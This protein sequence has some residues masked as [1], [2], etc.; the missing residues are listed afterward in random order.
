M[1]DFSKTGLFWQYPVITEKIFFNQNKRYTNYIGVPWAT[2]IDKGVDIETLYRLIKP[3]LTNEYNYTCCQ[4]IHYKRLIPLFKSLNITHLFISHKQIGRD[5]IND[6]KLKPCPLYAV[7]IEDENRN[8]LFLKNDVKLY[9]RDILYSFSGAYMQHYITDTRQKIFK[10]SHPTGCVVKNTGIWHFESQVYS[11]SQNEAGSLVKPSRDVNNYNELLLRSMFSLCPV[12][13]GPN[14]IRFWE[15]LGAGSI[16]VVLSD[17]FELPEH[18]LWEQSIVRVNESDVEKLPEILSSYSCEQIDIMRRNCISLYNFFK[19]NFTNCKFTSLS[20][21]MPDHLISSHYKC[22][23]HFVGDHVYMIYKMKRYLNSIGHNIQSINVNVN[24]AL[25][26]GFADRLYR[27]IFTEVTYNKKRDDAINAG[28]VLGSLAEDDLEPIYLNKSS[29]CNYF[30]SYVYEN[31][32]QITSN[33]LKILPE[34]NS[35]F[36]DNNRDKKDIDILFVNRAPGN[37]RYIDNLDKFTADTNLSIKIIF[38]ENL[39]IDEQIE[40]IKRSHKVVFPMGSTQAH[41]FWCD[42]RT[43]FFEIPLAGHRYINSLLYAKQLNIELHQIL[44]KY[45]DDLNLDIIRYH[46]DHLNP[47]ISTQLTAKQI[48]NEVSWFNK[49]LKSG[50]FYQRQYNENITLTEQMFE[51]IVSI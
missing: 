25:L 44:T 26:P 8:E 31:T 49:L 41:M 14:T 50:E 12:G 43:K 42:T 21:D 7:N 15:S 30:E 11:D 34:F 13:A 47:L 3:Q 23:I 18:H 10:M 39:D 33:N 46:N 1:I 35:L 9:E 2:V 36:S 20:V 51:Y 22:F 28:I 29:K 24:P 16:P 32:R 48:N 17:T 6:I 27:K 5:T 45:T 40:Y 37:G 38:C 19:N 4:H